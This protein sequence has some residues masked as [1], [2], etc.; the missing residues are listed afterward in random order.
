MT[1][2]NIQHVPELTGLSAYLYKRL[3]WTM[4]TKYL[5]RSGQASSHDSFC[6]R[7]PS[8]MSKLHDVQ[9]KTKVSVA[10][11]TQQRINT[12]RSPHVE[13]NTTCDSSNEWQ[14]VGKYES[15]YIAKP[16]A[17]VRPQVRE[18]PG[19]RNIGQGRHQQRPQSINPRNVILLNRT[20]ETT[21]LDPLDDV[22]SV[23]SRYIRTRGMSNSHE[24]GEITSQ[25]RLDIGNMWQ[26]LTASGES[27]YHGNRVGIS[28]SDRRQNRIR[29]NGTQAYYP[30]NAR[31]KPTN[32][33]LPPI[34]NRDQPI[35]EHSLV[36]GNS[37]RHISSSQSLSA[38]ERRRIANA[39][40]ALLGNESNHRLHSPNGHLDAGNTNSQLPLANDQHNLC[41]C[42]TGNSTNM[43]PLKFDNHGKPI[44]LTLW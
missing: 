26:R 38:R 31:I 21:T 42:C 20:S 24:L 29:P 8:N 7:S 13:K 43:C 17:I 5:V 25:E 19:K 41:G 1:A 39:N 37:R 40:N 30:F 33:Q 22:S 10:P 2:L 14:K 6:P 11:C 12:R 16:V 44:L 36:V 35:Q 23:S 32:R 9:S 15:G 3:P 27:L 28:I 18:P 4:D 34:S